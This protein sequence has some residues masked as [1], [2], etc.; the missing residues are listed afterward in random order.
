[1]DDHAVDIPLVGGS[2]EVVAWQNVTFST[3]SGKVILDNVSGAVEQGSLLAIMGPSGCGKTTLLNCLAQRQ[4]HGGK[5]SGEITFNGEPL[6]PS[7]AARVST[8][9]QQE[10]ALIGALTVRE[11]IDF[12]AK[13]SIKAPR[14]ERKERVA[15]L[16]KAF[17]LT[18]QSDTLVGTPIQK[19]I[20]GGQKRR[21]SVATQLI[22]LPRVVF[23]D[24]PTSGLDSLAAY[25]IM[26][27]LKQYAK[28][29]K[30]TVMA[31]IHSP[32]SATFKLF[33][34]VL[35][36]SA[37]RTVYHGPVVCEGFFQRAGCPIPSYYNPADFLLEVTNTDFSQE[38]ETL[39]SLVAFWQTSPEAKAFSVTNSSSQVVPTALPY[40]PNVLYQSL[41]LLHR[42]AI[43]SSRDVVVY[44]V[45]LA[46]YIGLALMMGTV[47]LRLDSAQDKIQAYI[48]AMFFSSA[49]MS[50]MAVAY[51][52]AY[53]EDY[54]CLI[55]DRA[56]GLY[57][58]TPFLI[59]NIVIG[60]PFLLIIALSFAVITYWLINLHQTTEAFFLYFMF[61]FLDLLAAEALVV[62][63]SSLIPIF[64]ASLA[65][66][67]F[68]N[69]LFMSSGG[70]LVAPSILEPVYKNFFY[71]IDY[72]RYTFEGLMKNEFGG[73]T[74]T[75][76]ST[77]H[78]MYQTDLAGACKIS[79]Q[80]VIDYL[81]YGG[82]DMAK[83][84][85]ILIACAVVMRLMSWGVLYLR[86]H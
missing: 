43:K 55:K 10:D 5:M 73:R 38:T 58:V 44:G 23:L 53:L 86:A 82:V 24:E 78:C 68:A 51:I 31:S 81:G 8:Y 28:D 11:T 79:G 26:A 37:G 35:L 83:W 9:V 77:C 50:F 70:F 75:C 63:V 29:Q 17:G 34:N 66:T 45:R 16:I 13:L 69:G 62:L 27:F 56:N 76:D 7:L 64:V 36:L 46:M 39:D 4:Q 52:P 15:A 48:N 71:Q 47:W 60:L 74:Y 54:S 80:G 67:A 41:Y 2:G 57:G 18:N 85:G 6:T 3:N 14:A 42:N 19:G 32:S 40:R 61:L 72:Q 59:A 30:L 65:I 1:M 25:E 20:S 49:F 12:A 33:D 84:A 22:T 21:L